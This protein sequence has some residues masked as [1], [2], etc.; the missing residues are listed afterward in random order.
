MQYGWLFLV[1]AWLLVHLAI[2]ISC[3]NFSIQQNTK[4]HTNAKKEIITCEGSFQGIL[5][6]LQHDALADSCLSV[7][8]M[9]QETV[10]VEQGLE[11]V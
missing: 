3:S 7:R 5:D 2:N 10:I 8:S 9:L 1:T 11:T 6:H 4:N